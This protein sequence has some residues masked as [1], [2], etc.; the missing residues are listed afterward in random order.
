MGLWPKFCGIAEVAAPWSGRIDEQ[1]TPA[2]DAWLPSITHYIRMLRCMRRVE[3]SAGSATRPSGSMDRAWRVRGVG[4]RAFR[5]RFYN[6]LPRSSFGSSTHCSVFQRQRTDRQAAD[7][8]SRRR[9]ELT[10]NEPLLAHRRGCQ[11]CMV[12]WTGGQARWC[13]GSRRDG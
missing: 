3:C 7:R 10:Q 2:V 13:G 1:Q 9:R 5:G 6:I 8:L 11:G 12:A 4:P